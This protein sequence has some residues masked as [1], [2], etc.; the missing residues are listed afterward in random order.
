MTSTLSNRIAG[1]CFPM[2]LILFMHF[3]AFPSYSQT[4]T[5]MVYANS[6]L[7]Q[8]VTDVFA[9]SPSIQ[10]LAHSTLSSMPGGEVYLP[11]SID[12]TPPVHVTIEPPEFDGTEI[13]LGANF[14]TVRTD[15]SDGTSTI[16]DYFMIDAYSIGYTFNPGYLY[17]IT[18]NFAGSKANDYTG[19]GLSM[20]SA[21]MTTDLTQTGSAMNTAF[22]TSA[23]TGHVLDPFLA[24]TF[25]SSFFH[26][27]NT[28][29]FTNLVIP[30]FSVDNPTTGLNIEALPSNTTGT[31][32]LKIK[33]I[34]I[35]GIPF[36]DQNT[37]PVCSSQTFSINSS[38]PVSWSISPAGIANLTPSGSSVTV[39][40]AGDGYATLTAGLTAPDGNVYQI[41]SR[42]RI[43]VGNPPI[44]IISSRTN[45][46]A[47]VATATHIPGATYTW[48]LNGSLE[49]GQTGY[50]CTDL[51]DCGISNPIYAVATTVCGSSQ[52]SEVG[53]FIKCNGG[54][55]QSASRGSLSGT[56]SVYPGDPNANGSTATVVLS[57]NP[58]QGIVRISASGQANGSRKIYAVRVIDLLGRV[59]RLL[60]YSTGIGDLSVDLSA[61]EN[62]TYT[63]QIFD[64]KD[65]DSHH[66]LL[67]KQ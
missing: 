45:G 54:G 8:T 58:T 67:L 28:Q 21:Q 42:S 24:N 51:V 48:Y 3:I 30:A 17:Y 1:R 50:T 16:N 23:S 63:I 15:Y 4:Y 40:K 41:S 32:Y 27:T 66:V 11:S 6:G 2:L 60:R 61:M 22:N 5:S 36:I 25:Y 44:S 10:G 20:G 46:A 7:D 26:I 29:T 37:S 49:I 34:T 14:T 13:K 35:V 31:I 43:Q 56:S 9:N 62:G 18:I 47:F 39:S 12:N 38:W 33:S 19:I 57:P 52:T 53:I 64:G 59:R 55:E 65:W